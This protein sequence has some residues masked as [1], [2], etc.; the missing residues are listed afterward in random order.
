MDDAED[1]DAAV[2]AVVLGCFMNQEQIC[3]S[4]ERIIVDEEIAQE[5]ATK[6]A[7]R[8]AA[9]P[10]GKP[11]EHVVLGGLAMS[12]A[13]EKMDALIADARE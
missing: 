4:T 10:A 7:A 8:A 1:V 11:R 3:M 9:L 6:F 5:F 12:G 13:G 2:N